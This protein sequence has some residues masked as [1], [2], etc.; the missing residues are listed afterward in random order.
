MKKWMQTIA[1]QR[2]SSKTAGLEIL[3]SHRGFETV[4]RAHVV[5]WRKPKVPKRRGRKVT[6]GAVF[7]QAVL[8]NLIFK[9][10]V[11]TDDGSKSITF[12]NVATTRDVIVAAARLAQKE[13]R[14]KD[15]EGIQGLNFS[16]GWVTKFLQRHDLKRHRISSV[17]ANYPSEADVRAKMEGI[18]GRIVAGAYQ[19]DQIISGDETGIFPGARPLHQYTTEDMPDAQNPETDEKRAH[20]MLCGS[21]G[22]CSRLFS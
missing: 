5:Y 4:S 8:D 1:R 19:P 2:S 20:W 6:G 15:D 21:C 22:I 3:R 13:E 17:S 11:L 9:E 18:Q 12:V 16:T 10:T 14:F 7:D